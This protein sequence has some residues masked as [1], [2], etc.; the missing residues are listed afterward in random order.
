MVTG[1]TPIPSK[2]DPKQQIQSDKSSLGKDDFMTLLVAQLQAQDPTN[3]MEAQDFSAQ[4]AQFSTVEQMFNVNDNLEA[5]QE[6]QI[7]L[8]N[9]SVLNLIGK[10]VNTS[11]NNFSYGE[12]ASVDL[13]YN[14][15]TDAKK[16]TIDI[17]NK[18][19]QIVA[20]IEQSD[21]KAG[22][23]AFNW[24]G[25]NSQGDEVASGDYTFNINAKDKLGN[26]IEAETLSVG[27]VSKVLFDEGVSY[28][29]VNGVK[30]PTSQITQVSSN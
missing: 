11:G 9:N 2:I 13:K 5:L 3:P 27:K 22:E 30:L 25:L 21:V 26:L 24:F 23:N 6:S 29:V 16:V 19:N 8:N 4:L 14:I 12:G 28:A 15:P 20:S 17:L 18:A 7:A 10:T 1:L